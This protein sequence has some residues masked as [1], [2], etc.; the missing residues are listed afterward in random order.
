MKSRTDLARIS[1]EIFTDT[2]WLYLDSFQHKVPEGRWIDP[3]FPPQDL[4]HH[5]EEVGPL[6]G[7]QGKPC[8]CKEAAWNHEKE[9]C[10][11]SQMPWLGRLVLL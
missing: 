4:P 9:P 3:L 5:H 11:W 8:K 6:K 7:D 10:L 2:V 1:T